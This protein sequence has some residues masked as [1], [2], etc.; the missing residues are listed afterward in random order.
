MLGEATV[1]TG[2]FG[3]RL[4]VALRAMPARGAGSRRVAGSDEDDRNPSEF[5]LVGDE[6]LKLSKRPSRMLRPV[7]GSN[8]GP[9]AD[10]LEILKPNSAS[11]VFG[12]LDQGVGN[13]VV[14][15]PP[16]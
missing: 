3:L 15:I 8:R 5:R 4:P 1:E 7:L 2:E 14:L 10:V 13:A 9:V 6:G 11:G 16:K 12:P